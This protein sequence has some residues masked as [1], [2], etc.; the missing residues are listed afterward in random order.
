TVNVTS[1]VSYSSAQAWGFAGASPAITARTAPSLSANSFTYSMPAY[2]VIHFVLASNMTPT[3]TP[4]WTAT[5]TFTHTVTRT[6]TPDWTA[7]HTPTA[8]R[9]VTRTVTR[10]ASP[11]RTV[12]R[13]VTVTR[14]RTP[15]L[16]PTVTATPLPEYGNIKVIPALCDYSAGCNSLVFSGVPQNSGIRI[17]DISGGLVYKVVSVPSGSF[18]WYLDRRIASGRIAPGT[19]MYVV[20]DEKGVVARGKV[21]VVR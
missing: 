20:L 2:S 18:T 8:S 10:T 7:T 6:N 4:N 13:T 17:Y 14:T 1:G 19:Y 3:N 15:Y 21:G 9:T 5:P 12:T 11:T 16:S